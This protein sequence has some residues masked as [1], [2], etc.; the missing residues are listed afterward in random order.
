M[1]HPAR[2][3]IIIIGGGFAGLSVA[4]ALNPDHDVLLIDERNF[5]LFQPLLYQVA[6]GQL[7]ASDIATPLRSVLVKRRNVIVQ[8]RQALD[9]D[10]QNRT[11]IFNDG[12]ERYDRLIVATGVQHSYFGHEEWA[13]SAPGLKTM[14]QAFAIRAQLFSVFERAEV[15]ATEAERE[16]LL[17]I[18]VVGAGPTG[19]ELAGAIAELT[20][21]VLAREFRRCKPDQAKV[22]LVEGSGQVLPVYPPELGAAAERALSRMG[23]T[24]LKN[25]V[26]TSLDGRLA[27]IRE[28]DQ[29]STLEV[30]AVFWAAGVAPSGFGRILAEKTRAKTDRAGRICVDADFSVP[31]APDI[32]VLGDL[33]SYEQDGKPLPGVAT[34]A[35]AEGQWLAKYFN[36]HSQG[37]KTAAFRYNDRGSLAV[38]GRNEAVAKLGRLHFSGRFAWWLWLLVHIAGIIGF[39]AKVKVLVTWAWKFVWDKYAARLITKVEDPRARSAGGSPQ[40]GSRERLEQGRTANG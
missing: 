28:G 35:L 10:V 29:S 40:E 4:N 33:A 21:R 2:K 22:L 14:E 34:V 13:G 27:T 1:D 39:D 12:C 15:A 20:R 36:A 25:A 17:R 7:A 5:H 32:H 11:V 16:A 9:I 18:M 31:S 3:R 19:V 8:Q 37:R 23:A 24:V 38:I 26:V 30:G 6:T